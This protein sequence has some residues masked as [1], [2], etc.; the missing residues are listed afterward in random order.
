MTIAGTEHSPIAERNA[1]H[2]ATCDDL[3]S[4]CE[5][6]AIYYRAMADK[7]LTVAA[8]REYIRKAEKNEHRA[9]VLRNYKV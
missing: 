4:T 9:H 8:R 6:A 5:T 1:R 7:A 3:A 2:N